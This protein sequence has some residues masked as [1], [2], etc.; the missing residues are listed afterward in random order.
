ML[1]NEAIL[2]AVSSLCSALS[3]CKILARR[4]LALLRAGASEEQSFAIVFDA[5][6][7]KLCASISMICGK[8]FGLC[9]SPDAMPRKRVIVRWKMNGCVW[10]SALLS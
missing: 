9:S 7:G 5:V 6:C 8:T 4:A 1:N 2:S 10:Q 3:L